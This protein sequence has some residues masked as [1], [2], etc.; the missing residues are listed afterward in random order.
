[1]IEIT[2]NPISPEP[3]ISKVMKPDYGAVITFIGTIRNTSQGKKVAYL[4]RK[5]YGETTGKRLREIVSE[6]NKRWQLQ[7]IVICCRTGK[8]NVGEIGLVIAVAAPHR[9]EA[10]QA[11]QY[12][13][14]SI[15][16]AG[17]VAEKEA[18]QD[19]PG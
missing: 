10:F 6:I 18:Y 15:K 17:V 12:A 2:A 3:I 4:E 16:Q 1:M 14:D 5:T 19:S 11:C 9:Q 13:V 7:D 8:L